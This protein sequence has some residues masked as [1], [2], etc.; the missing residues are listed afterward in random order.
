[1]R[2]LI[3]GGS[4]EASAL[5]RL[6]AGEPRIEAT[7]SLAGR[8]QHPAAAPI[9]LRV[10]GFGG[11]EGLVAHLLRERVEA[12]IDATHP[13]AA[14]MSRHA[15][16]ACGRLGLPH[17]VLTRAPWAQREGDRW[18]EVE[19]ATGAAAALGAAPR[20]V[21][22]TVGRLSV[23]AFAVSPRHRYLIRTIEAPRGLEA[24]PD[25]RLILARPPFAL[26]DEERLMREEGIEILVSK[27]S[28]GAA[29]YAKIEAARELGLRVVMVRRP[30]PAC[31]HSVHEPEEALAWILRQ[32]RA[33]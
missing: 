12:V 2:I 16:E 1:M 19:D 22:L 18:I 15:A 28:G 7:L 23:P 33:P 27:N 26:A 5:A 14:Q 8:T 32:G 24:L 9:A 13:F 3:L 4:S 10:G 31:G 17:I 30:K 25:H 6:V 11:V 21:F 20:R 29:S